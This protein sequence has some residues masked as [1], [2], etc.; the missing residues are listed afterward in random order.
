MAQPFQTPPNEQSFSGLIDAAILATGRPGQLTAA[1]Q[2]ANVVVRECQ[3]LG[4]F[5]QDMIEDSFVVS[6]ANAAITLDRPPLFRSLRTV[7][8]VTANVYPDLALPGKKQKNKENFFYAA[9][10][11]FVFKGPTTGEIVAYA[12]YYWSKPLGY[13]S[14]LGVSTSIFPSGPYAIRPAYYD[15]N[16]S[17]WQYLNADEDGYEDT[18]GSTSEDEARQKLVSNWLVS[19]WYDLILSGTKTKIWTS[20]GDPR[21]ATEYS[22]YKQLQKT[23]QNTSAYEG[24]AF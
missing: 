14:R 8:Y 20:A 12:T 24:E 1:V 16:E 2:F 10:N 7:K 23:L 9:D 4:L 22:V 15:L 3:A 21:G 11:Y 6:D 13:Y 17:K 5:A 19:S 18:T